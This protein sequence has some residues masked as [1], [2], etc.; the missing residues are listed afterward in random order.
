ML[1]AH[2]LGVK[3]PILETPLELVAPLAADME[4]LL[5]ILRGH[6]SDGR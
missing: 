3:H 5:G 4:E 2:R 6:E 1:H